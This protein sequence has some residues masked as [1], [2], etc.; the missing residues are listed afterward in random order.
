MWQV[1]ALPWRLPKLGGKSRDSSCDHPN[2][3][4]DFANLNFSSF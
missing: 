4:P 2:A 1:R 3:N